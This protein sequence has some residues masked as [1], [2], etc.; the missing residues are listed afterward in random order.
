MTCGDC[1]YARQGPGSMLCGHDH[2]TPERKDYIHGGFE[3]CILFEDLKWDTL[4]DEDK[5][6]LGFKKRIDGLW[7]SPDSKYGGFKY[8]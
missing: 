2:S 5:I 8:E 4:T 1:L 3:A 7:S 6:K